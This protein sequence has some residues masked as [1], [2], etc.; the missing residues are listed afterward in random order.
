MGLLD[1]LLSGGNEVGGGGL[2]DFLRGNALN[3][4]A[5]PGLQSDQAQYAQPMSAMAQMQPTFAPPIA[6][7][8][9]QPSLDSARWPYGPIGAPSQANA[10][11]VPQQPPPVVSAQPQPQTAVAPSPGIGESIFSGAR[12]AGNHLA[13]GLQSFANSGGPLPA[14]ANG[15]TGLLSGQRTDPSGIAERQQAQSQNLTLQ[16]LINKG[17]DPATAQA[18]IGN[19]E[20]LKTLITQTYGP[21]TLTS[22]GD[23]YVAD[24]SGKITRA[25][26]PDKSPLSLG[27]GYI[28]NPKTQK[29][30]R[31]YEPEDKTPTS[32]LEYNFYVKNLPEGERP[33]SYQRW[34]ATKDVDPNKNVVLGRG[35]EIVKN[36]PDGSVTVLHKNEAAVDAPMLSE[37]GQHLLAERILN[38]EKGVTAGF[39]RS[40]GDMAGIYNKVAEKAKER[41]LDA[42]DILSNINNEYAAASASRAFGG[43]TAKQET[44]SNTAAKAIDIAE[45]ASEAVPRTTW[46]PIN[47]AILAYREK[48]GDPKVAALG[49]SLETLTQEYARA[50][51]GGHGTV[52]DKEE[53]REYLAKAQTHEQLVARFNIM[54]QE[55][56]RGRESVGESAAHVGGIYR[57]N[58]RRGNALPDP[59]TKEA[60]ALTS[61]PDGPKPGAYTWSPDKGVSPK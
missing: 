42:S 44:Y 29:V 5:S 8:N 9:A 36:N 48:S 40:K 26:Q 34:L 37:E 49:Q 43:M 53:A 45:K 58:I 14:L 55:I 33:V 19:P 32:A 50:V 7:Q 57:G 18:A 17:V 12:G 28:Y 51:G 60:E 2:L 16:A 6:Q 20:L 1:A 15:I 61:P 38:G 46:V 4:Q 24:K 47:K 27:E 52:S 25:Y 13:A 31:A 21:Q 22:L 41:G 39:A 23:G 10:Q 35:G 30:E 3:Q 11:A 56:A 54:R 59:G